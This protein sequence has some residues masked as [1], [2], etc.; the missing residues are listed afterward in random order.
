MQLL[1]FL[2]PVKEGGG[3]TFNVGSK[4]EYSDTGSVLF[5]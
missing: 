3:L 4:I 5:C 1:V 2:I